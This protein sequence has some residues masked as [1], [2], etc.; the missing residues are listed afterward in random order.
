MFFNAN[1]KYEFLTF[2]CFPC[3]VGKRQ[4]GSPWCMTV[5]AFR[6]CV[7]TTCLNEEYDPFTEANLGNLHL[8]TRSVSA[9]APNS[10]IPSA[11]RP[12]PYSATLHP[13][14]R[15]RDH[16]HHPTAMVSVIAK[17]IASR[18]THQGRQVWIYQSRR[19]GG[20]SAPALVWLV[21]PRHRSGQRLD[22]R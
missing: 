11:K 18:R 21:R 2:N 17:N 7:P 19:P 22:G 8:S 3:V 9:L 5:V 1:I 6:L 15:H 12:T 14:H 10:S 16:C 13:V 4:F 20:G